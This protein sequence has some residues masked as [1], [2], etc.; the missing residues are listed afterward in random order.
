MEF[1]TTWGAAHCA[2]LRQSKKFLFDCLSGRFP[3]ILRNFRKSERECI[4]RRLRSGKYR[5]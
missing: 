5:F 4:F 2:A 1:L 3:E